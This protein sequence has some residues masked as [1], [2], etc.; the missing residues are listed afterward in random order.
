MIL[1]E[2]ELKKV[3]SLMEKELKNFQSGEQTNTSAPDKNVKI[4]TLDNPNSR[5]PNLSDAVQIKY[6]RG[7]GRF[8]VAARDINIGSNKIMSHCL[9]SKC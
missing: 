1:V 8:A 7:R 9:R 6:A 4:L 3:A 5:F 2:K